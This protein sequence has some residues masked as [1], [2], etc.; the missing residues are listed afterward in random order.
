MMQW[1]HEDRRAR[2]QLEGFG[3]HLL[4]PALL[5]SCSTCDWDGLPWG[6]K[7]AQGMDHGLVRAVSYRMRR[8]SQVLGT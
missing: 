6:R 8:S 1:H 2:T 7:S 3:E 4:A 5:C